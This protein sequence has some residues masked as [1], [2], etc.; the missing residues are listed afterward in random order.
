M[1]KTG[2][3][4]LL[5][6][7]RPGPGALARQAQLEDAARN[8]KTLEELALMQ[9]EAAS[10]AADAASRAG[11]SPPAPGAAEADTAPSKR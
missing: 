8:L 1:K 11:A 2:Y 9:A 4:S 5:E 6:E 7:R 10:R 3:E